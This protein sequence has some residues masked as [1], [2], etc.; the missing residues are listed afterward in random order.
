[1]SGISVP[2]IV[3]I[4]PAVISP[5]LDTFNHMCGMSKLP[6]TLHLPGLFGF[7]SFPASDELIRGVIVLGSASSV[8]D[9]LPWQRPLEG[10]LRPLVFGCCYGHQMIAHMYGGKIGFVRPDRAKLVGVRRIQL[11]LDEFGLVGERDYIVTHNAIVTK[12]PSEFE[13]IATS[14]EIEVEGLRHRKRPIFS[15]QAHPEATVDFLRSR[16]L[17]EHRALQ[18]L[19][20]GHEVLQFFL[21]YVAKDA[22]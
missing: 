8:Y 20:C 5:E 11:N 15:L 2:H 6:M 10:W 19:V 4:D 12:V 3:V 17:I 1:M 7:Q 22:A 16:G 13:V 18:A 21:D 9:G 14:V